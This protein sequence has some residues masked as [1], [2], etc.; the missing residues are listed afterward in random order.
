MKR[1]WN[2]RL[3]L[4]LAL[5]LC[6]G[7]VTGGFLYSSLLLVILIPIAS[8]A[9]GICLFFITK[10]HTAWLLFLAFSVG[11]ALFVADNAI[12]GP[13]LSGE[14]TLTMKV[15]QA[16]EDSGRVVLSADD[17]RGYAV[18]Y[19]KDSSFTEG[20]VVLVSGDF[21]KV[22][23]DY[24]DSYKRYLYSQ[25][26]SYTVDVS[27]IN[28]IGTD[29]SVFDKIRLRT[30][31]VMRRYMTEEDVAFCMSLVFGD[32]SAL[33]EE[34][35][36]AM[37]AA[38]LSHVLAVSG[39]HVGFLTAAIV[40]LLKRLRVGRFPQ[41]IITLGV[42]L[43]YGLFTGFPP[44]VKRS[45]IT[46]VVYALAPLLRRKQ[47]KLS[48]LS[49]A[50]FL[51]VLTD[52]REL[53]DVGFL[54]SAGAVLGILSFYR[55]LYGVVARKVKNKFVL[56]FYGI[57]CVTLS[58]NVFVLP[59]SLS[60]FSAF[61]VYAVIG[62]LIVLPIVTVAFP[63]VFFSSLLSAAFSGFGILFYVLKYPI[64]AIRL[65]A[66]AISTLPSAEI[67]SVDMGIACVTYVLFF[68]FIGRFSLLKI[69]YKVPVCGMLAAGTVLLLLF[70]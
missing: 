64:I 13:D 25:R 26:I 61:S 9:V 37:S 33:S 27:E 20:D 53:F 28:V 6:A 55:P 29:L 68:V 45:V 51:I 42:L 66:F 21:K 34:T 50:V 8:F 65:F 32:K 48:T 46:Y 58:A 38:G 63:L 59:V 62:N 30:K 35:Q 23:F 14:Q 69:R 49:A 70:V 3:F 57:I 2:Y 36:S 43:L 60:V 4:F 67:A 5:A 10:K 41:W 22:E 11:I 24:T 54:M 31:R 44:G 19:R 18:F 15:E 1:I 17:M 39:L 12:T 7:V 52:P 40:F 56:Y 16:R 47:D